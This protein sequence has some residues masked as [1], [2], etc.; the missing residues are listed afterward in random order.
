[1]SEF[2]SRGQ[3]V[4]SR[5]SGTPRTWKRAVLRLVI[6]VAMGGWVV[7]AALAA[8]AGGS[9]VITDRCAGLCDLLAAGI[10]AVVLLL[11]LRENDRLH[12][13][14][15][16]AEATVGRQVTDVQRLCGQLENLNAA[17]TVKNR[18]LLAYRGQVGLPTGQRA[19]TSARAKF[20]PVP[21][22]G[23]QIVTPKAAPF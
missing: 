15:V 21:G 22:D 17:L 7:T 10:A 12:A 3:P 23:L 14:L 11:V 18:Q 5:V 20:R 6:A 1:M 16:N 8:L 2:A 19:E 4:A 13:K 9:G